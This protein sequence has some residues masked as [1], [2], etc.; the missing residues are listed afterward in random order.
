M[1]GVVP[2]LA[3]AAPVA[4]RLPGVYQEDAFLQR[5]LEAFDEALA[6][7]LATLDGLAGYVDPWLAPEDFLD[8]IAG[9][10]G[11]DLDDAW[12]VTERREAVAGAALTHRRRGTATGV[13]QAVRLGV[14]V[15]AEVTE[16][17]GSAWSAAPGGTLAAEDEP[18]LHVR[19]VVADPES[20]DV[21]RV[22][23]LVTAAKPAHVPHTVEVLAGAGSTGGD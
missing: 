17:G 14:G 10:V 11:V 15:E 6:P 13:A 18:W 22:E 2:G 4:L 7:V 8:W 1:R 12:N 21:R 19:V 23:A 9:W 5:F 20:F 3:S 16:S